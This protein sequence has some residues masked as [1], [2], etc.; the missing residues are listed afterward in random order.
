[1]I[2]LYFPL[3]INLHSPRPI[4]KVN[5]NGKQTTCMLDTGAD[6]PVYCKGIEL[7]DEW[8][9][10]VGGVSVFRNFSIGGFGKEPENAVLYNIEDFWLSD[11]KNGIVMAK[12]R[13]LF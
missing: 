1:M 9:R 7:F 13:R 8:M 12:F 4:F 10:D 2:R 11:G 3:K 6:I 5:I